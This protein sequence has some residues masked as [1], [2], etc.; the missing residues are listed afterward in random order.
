MKKTVRSILSMA[1]LMIL[2]VAAIAQTT[3]KGVVVDGS[4]N[5]TL[6]G[7]SI[8]IP[9]TAT[10]TVT[11]LDGTFVFEVPN[12]TKSLVVSFVGFLNK[13]LT[14]NGTQDLGTIKLESDAVGLSEISV[15][16]SVAIDRQTPV[17]V[18]T[19]SP[20]LIAEKL[21]TQE[22]P[23]ML[24]STPGVYATKA[25]GGYGDSRINLRGFESNNIGV[26][27]NGVPINGMENGKVYWS[28][29]AGLSD[30]TRS[31]QVQRGLGASKVATP[32][33]GGT[34]NILTNS[35]DAKKGGSFS[36]G[37]GNNGMEKQSLTLSTGLL[38]NGWAVTFSGSRTKGDGWVKS[39][40]YEGWSYFLSVGKQI[41]DA[42]RLTFTVFG[43]PQW[44]NQRY[45][46]GTIEDYKNH[47]DGS[48][49]NLDYGFKNG[50]RFNTAYNYYHKP[51]AS[52]NHYWQIN[53]KTTLSTSVYASISEGGG[54]STDG[55]DKYWLR[56]DNNGKV[57]SS[58]RV[59]ADGYLDYDSVIADNAA[60]LSG[61]RAIITN[62]VNSHQW[63]G[64]L[65][66]LSTELNENLKLSGG[67]DLRYYIGQHSTKIDDLLGGDYFVDVDNN[68]AS[69][70][71]NRAANTKLKKGDKIYYDNPGEIMW[72]GLFSQ[73][74]YQK[75]A[76]SAFV[77]ASVTESQYR[78]TDHFQY[79]PG[80]QKTA[81]QDFLGYSAKAG[82]NYNLDEKNN[83][84]VNVGY[85]EK[86]PFFNSVF[87]NYANDINPDAENEK[88]YSAEVGYGFRSNK[89]SVNINGYYTKWMDK[90]IATTTTIRNEDWRFNVL[91]LD[92]LHMGVEMDMKYQ[93][94]NELSLTG[95]A[96][97]GDWEWISNG[98]ANGVNMDNKDDQTK[99]T[100]TIYSDGLKVG[101]AAQ[102]TAALGL[103]YQILDDLKIG[104][105][106]N[107]Y[108]NL[109]AYFNVADRDN[110]NDL[111]QAWEMPDYGLFD[112]NVKYNF[113]L[114]S[115]KATVY[116][117]VQ[118]VF[119]TEYFS[120]ATD[121]SAHDWK[122]SYGF[123]GFGRTASMRLKIKF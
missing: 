84:F 55:K 90:S 73:L 118:N 93:I 42:H 62:S 69:K 31:Q 100:L 71:I 5:E 107:Y 74:E 47:K 2:S 65:S 58:T 72:G 6:P 102:T 45:T 61:S 50:E 113:M 33:V 8:I 3:V 123:Y 114:G 98:T 35:T 122:T 18:S 96:S 32:A 88:V 24:K 39:T 94:T 17:A 108:A 120:D 110:A 13:E 9:G 59:T 105:N 26:M 46:R 40:D 28:N 36:Y 95:M 106:Y 19:I 29:W 52:L 7:A 43:A 22:F 116:G 85:F 51:Q 21:G 49:R 54:R 60:S 30:V 109:Y 25:G 82:A 111:S 56:Y 14:L 12:G 86:A 41:N 44:H 1:A 70:N 63:Y 103:D 34:I 89:L 20:E 117:N 87:L 77:S 81:W 23:E 67:V 97:M 64:V 15:L 99:E 37:I 112:L 83:V 48:R 79:L 38:D 68:G 4:T 121:G 75:D 80:N 10:G 101:D 16:A 119:N 57:G 11:G 104:M 66:N 115:L 53:E 27:I 76:L 92:A 78:R 91:G